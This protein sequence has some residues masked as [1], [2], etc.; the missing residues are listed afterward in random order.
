MNKQMYYLV[1]HHHWGA[2]CCVADSVKLLANN[3]QSEVKDR[4]GLVDTMR[5]SDYKILQDGANVAGMW[6][7]KYENQGYIDADALL[8]Q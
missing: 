7:A 5:Y 1:S 2:T 4:I 8:Y 3:I 6:H